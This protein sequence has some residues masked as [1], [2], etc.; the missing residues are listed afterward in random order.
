MRWLLPTVTLALAL[1]ACSD[2]SE[3]AG[4]GASPAPQPATAYDPALEPAAAVLSLV[5][6]EATVLEVTDFD[7]LRLTLGF[8]DGASSGAER[9]RFWGA[10]DRAAAF[11]RG[12]LR[13]V[14]QRLLGLGLSADDVAWEA[15]WSG[16]ADG[17]VVALHDGVAPAAVRSAVRQGVGVL[18]GAEYDARRQL[19]LSA[20]PPDADASWAAEPAVAGLVGQEANATYVERGCVAFD[21]VYG[22]GMEEQLAAAPRA[23]LDALDPLEAYSVAFGPDLATVRLGDARDDAFARL[24]IHEVLPQT[25]PEFGTVFSRGV[26]DPS[27][28]RLG[29]DVA[30]PLL[31]VEM[32]RSRRLPFAL[33]GD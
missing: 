22:A 9:R 6:A 14:E 20:A 12:M 11:S 4:P 7:Q 27:T 18:G 8:G 13:P 23:E 21:D 3:P 19:V 32:T 2:T 16:G 15:R 29:Y 1:A 30:R 25:R 24:R 26:S 31:A 33:C 10:V 5:P 28:G 17:W